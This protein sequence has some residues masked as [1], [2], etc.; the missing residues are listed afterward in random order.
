MEPW[1]A[2]SETVWWLCGLQPP[3][4]P[5]PSAFSIGG[6]GGGS[7]S[8]A[9]GQKQAGSK[10]VGDGGLPKPGVAGRQETGLESR[11]QH[12]QGQ[13]LLCHA[14]LGYVPALVMFSELQNSPCHMDE[15]EKSNQ[16]N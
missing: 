9:R 14:D 13:A 15:G 4:P 5:P 8:Q 11:G 3:Q 7:S 2:A 1:R 12:P 10:G 16:Q 6:W